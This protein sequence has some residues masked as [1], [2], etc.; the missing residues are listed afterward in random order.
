MLKNYLTIAFRNLLKNK[1]HSAINIF[2][3]AVAFV[4]SILLFLT[5]YFDFSYDNFHADKERIYKVYQFANKAQGEELGSGMSYPTA[6]TIKNEIQDIEYSSRYQTGGSLVNYHNKEINVGISYVDNDFLNI[7]SFPVLSG[8]KANPLAELGN[9]VITETTAKK[10]FNTEDPIGK[11]IKVKVSGEWKDLAVTAVLKELPRNSSIAFDVLARPEL[12]KDY[13]KNKDNWNMQ[14]HAVYVKLSPTALQ[15]NVEEKLRYIVKKVHPIDEPFLKGQGYVANA[16]GDYFGMRLLPLMEE[17]F[18]GAIGSGNTT[19]KTYLYMIVLIGF[20]IMAIACFNFI[21]LNVARAF[22]RMKEVGVRKCLGANKSQIFTQIWGES[23]IICT[24]AFLIGILGATILLPEYNKLM[25]ARL[26]LSLFKEPLTIVGLIA[27]M[28]LVSLLAGGY[29]AWI[30]SK[31]NTVSVLKGK[32]SFKKSGIFRNALIVL[33]FTIACL[34]MICT[35]IAFQQF[36]YMRTKPLGFNQEAVI[37]IPISS[38]DKG[39]SILNQFRNRVASQPAI[40][41][42]TGSDVNIG[43]G[44]DGDIS[45]SSSGFGYNGNSIFTNTIHVYYDFLKTMDIKLL[46]GRDFNA[47]FGTDTLNSVI[48]TE[49]LA[50]QFKVKDPIGLAFYSDS[51][52]PKNIIIGVVPDFHLYSLHEDLEPTMLNFAKNG[53]LGYILVKT[54][55]KNP[56]QTMAMVENI[57]KDLEPGKPFQGSFIDENTNRWYEKEKKLSQLLGIS[58]SIAILLSCL[59]LFAIALLMIEQRVKEIGVRKVLGASVTHI[60]SL[61]SKDFLQLVIIAILIASPVAWWAM[62][63]WLQDFPYRIAISWWIFIL[64]GLAALLIA[65]FTVSFQAIKAAVANPVKSLRTE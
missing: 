54:T 28:V 38:Y 40:L 48:I 37:S 29:P 43:I 52:Q 17:H 57:Y 27:G 16:Q 32:V 21:N 12:R 20:F 5:A 47:S 8:N 50:K 33:Q 51:S 11:V 41:S 10:V 1:T 25:N 44:K 4:C 7:F 59:G 46:E 42:V 63:K 53:F 24:I 62:H 18:N 14:N 64:T 60:T 56:T 30:V 23:L 26:N 58:S 49:G 34:L 22:T 3:L 9:V 2:G 65:L 61:L 13:A 35:V 55:G 39:Q 45:K 15:K 31:F 19:S 6:P 36:E